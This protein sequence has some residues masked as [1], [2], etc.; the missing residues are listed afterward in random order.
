MGNFPYNTHFD[1]IAEEEQSLGYP[2]ITFMVH[3][4]NGYPKQINF[5]PGEPPNPA[6]L[7]SLREGTDD[8]I[9]LYCPPATKNPYT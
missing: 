4:V 9:R 1:K 7:A 5:R 6:Q 8:I 3:G 2:D